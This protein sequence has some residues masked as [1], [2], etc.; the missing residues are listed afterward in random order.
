MSRALILT[1]LMLVAAAQEAAAWWSTGHMISAQI[2][3]DRLSPEA[4]SEA[5][6]LIAVLAAIEPKIDHF[7]PAAHWLDELKSDFDLFDT[8]HYIN[9]PLHGNE[10]AERIPFEKVPNDNVIWAIEEATRTLGDPQ[11]RDFSR[12]LALRILLHL[13][14]DIHQPLH[15]VNRIGPADPEGDLGATLLVVSFEKESLD[16]HRAWDSS[17]GLFPSILPSDDWRA[18]IPALAERLAL[19][20]PVATLVNATE[21]D[22]AVMAGESYRLAALYAYRGVE[23]GRPLGPDYLAVARPI[24]KERL[25]LAGYRLAHLLEPLLTRR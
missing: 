25:A 11:A 8:W 16:L 10:V 19:E 15:C 12:A 5:N 14:G 2:A 24:I 6:R 21:K 18:T 1:L 22:P 7:V 9:L 13:I 3:Y 20:V 23:E 17:L 4:R